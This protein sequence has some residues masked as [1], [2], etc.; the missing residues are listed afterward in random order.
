MG[1]TETTDAELRRLVR[2]HRKALAMFTAVPCATCELLQPIFE[3]FA[4]NQAYADI[5][6]LR[7]NADENPEAKHFMNRQAAPF[8]VT[9]C[10]G[11]VVH[12]EALSTEQQLR[13]MA[14]ALL[15]HL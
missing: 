13:A 15:A 12:G 10:H 11:R 3:A 7:V 4:S 6:F 1:I 5:V 14:N 8:F 9:Y 2:S